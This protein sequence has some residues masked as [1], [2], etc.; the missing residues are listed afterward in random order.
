MNDRK[1]LETDSYKGV[2]DFYPEELAVRRAVFNTI[3]KTLLLR[4]FEEYDASPLE[5]SELYE[6]KTSEEIVNDQT[7]TFVDRGDRRVTLRP[8]MTPTLARMVAAKRHEL[9]FPVR[10]FN[11]GNRFRYE[12]PQKGRLREFYQVDVDIIGI[13]GEKAEGEAVVTA[14]DLLCALGAKDEDF[15]IRISSRV[16]VNAA[17]K[18]AGLT[19]E[20]AG[21]YIA[22]L[23]RKAKM[24][25]AQFMEERKEF[26]KGSQDPLEL[27]EEGGAEA[28]DTERARLTALLEA[29]KARGMNNVVFDPTVVRGFLY[30]TGLVF[31]IFDT[32]PENPRAL[33]GGGRYDELVSMFGGSPIPAIGFA[34][35]DVT[36]M[37]F[38]STHGILPAARTGAEVF[39]GTPEDSDIPL[40][41]EFAQS[42]RDTGISTIVH[43][44]GKGLG[45]QVKEAV[46]RGIPYFVAYG[47]EEESTSMVR[48]KDLAR[49]QEESVEINQVVK[50]LSRLLGK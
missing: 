47:K 14:Y 20:E 38:L 10:W 8:E 32:S 50:H 37:D 19:E 4:G 15:T 36:L 45:D 6:R 48:I 30:Y 41:Q 43:V 35:G 16:L 28:V 46:R 11:I 39:I 33:F 25:S 23:D 3:R 17:T 24:P 7:Y 9:A 21:R 18:A 5:R 40:A 27:I 2:R 12:R 22:L 1:P 29:F 44:S 42:L 49:S 26:R 34:F 13:P 31:E